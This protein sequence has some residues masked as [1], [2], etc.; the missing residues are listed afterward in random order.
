MRGRIILLGTLAVFVAFLAFA[1]LGARFSVAK[2]PGAAATDSLPNSS[3]VLA[4]G[5]TNQI[6]EQGFPPKGA[7]ET[8]WKVEWDTVRGNG[9]I[10]KNAWFKTGP[11][12]EWMQV[13]GDA[14]V[15]DLFVPYQPG[16]PR[17][18]DV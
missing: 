7:M 2:T 18:W 15:A 8:K 10:I 6:V 1:A 3:P 16:S 4:E 11:D 9:L 17:F 12:R 5:Q 14:R 13:L